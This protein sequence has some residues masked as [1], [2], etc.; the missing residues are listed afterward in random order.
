MSKNQKTKTE[1]MAETEAQ[2]D[3]ASGLD[4]LTQLPNRAAWLRFCE[5]ALTKDG[6]FKKG[7]QANKEIA[8]KAVLF[9]DLDRFKWVNDSLGHDAGDELLIKV[10]KCLQ[11]ELNSELHSKFQSNPALQLNESNYNTINLVGRMGGDEFVAFIQNP[12]SIKQLDTLTQ[13]LV[14]VLSQPI[15]LSH[16]EVE[17]GASIGIAHYPQDAENLSD[18]LKFADLAMYRAKHSG[19]NQVVSYHPQMIRKIQYRRDM[20]TAIRKALREESLRLDFQPIFDAKNSE[21]VSIEAV[22]N[23]EYC[24]E[25]SVLDQVEVFS[26]ADESQV[27]IQLSEW[28][29]NQGLEF[30]CGLQESEVE[31]SLVVPVRPS[32]F[33][34]KEFVDWLEERLEFYD[35]SPEIIVLNLNDQ[36]LNSQRF[37]VEKQLK[38]LSKQGV[39]VALQNFGSGH[40]SP[41]RLHDW[42]IE[43]LHLSPLFVSEVANKRSMEA[44]AIALIQ[45]GIILNKKVVAYGVQTAEQFEFLK[46]QQCYFMQGDFLSESLSAQEIEFMLLKDKDGSH[47]DGASQGGFL[48]EFADDY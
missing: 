7:K 12:E 37:P 17:I 45:M 47:H 35:L 5:K 11:S 28:I 9:I 27:A 36:C 20:Q 25:L 2:S 33:H 22:L 15:Q 10:A 13:R 19:R 3:I 6:Q 42:P 18:L 29:I 48:D 38:Q 14:D 24:A 31:V 39:E 41:L 32:H 16:S 21:I 46:S 44:M 30:I 4:S 43:R 8:S 26:I 34:A 23:L 40:L 1:K